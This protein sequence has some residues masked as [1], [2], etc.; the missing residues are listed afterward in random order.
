MPGCCGV[1]NGLIPFLLAD[2]ALTLF[3]LPGKFPW[4]T[5]LPEK[6]SRVRLEC[7]LDDSGVSF[8]S[9]ATAII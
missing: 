2:L 8:S 1:V 3:S 5:H 6:I 7:L 4:F 9:E